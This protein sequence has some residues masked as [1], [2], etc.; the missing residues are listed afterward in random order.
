MQPV[1]PAAGAQQ[2]QAAPYNPPPSVA[3]APL[4]L[5][6]TYG[7]SDAYNPLTS[8]DST[9][10]TSLSSGSKAA[11][12][13]PL[14]IVAL[15]ILALGGVVWY[16]RHPRS[17]AGISRRRSYGEKDDMSL[18]EK[19]MIPGYGRKPS[20]STSIR[21]LASTVIGSSRG[22]TV[23][24]HIDVPDLARPAPSIAPSI[25]SIRRPTAMNLTK[26][27]PPIS[28]Y[29]SNSSG[30]SARTRSTVPVIA[31]ATVARRA[32]AQYLHSPSSP[33]PR[34]GP[35]TIV[36]EGSVRSEEDGESEVSTAYTT[37]P[38]SPRARMRAS[39]NKGYFATSRLSTSS[40]GGIP[41]NRSSPPA[42][43]VYSTHSAP[44]PRSKRSGPSR[45]PIPQHVYPYAQSLPNSI[46]R[47]APVS[48]ARRSPA[49]APALAHSPQSSCE[50]ES[51][52]E[53][54]DF[55]P[56]HPFARKYGASHTSHSSSRSKHTKLQAYESEDA[57]SMVRSITERTELTLPWG[58]AEAKKAKVDDGVKP[59]RQ[60]TKESGVKLFRE[61]TRKGADWARERQL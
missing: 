44:L 3:A 26:P 6:A 43:S 24:P 9:T 57:E 53:M 25:A 39:Q 50:S 16:K 46:A 17:G 45:R 35:E 23:V 58:F 42:A 14:V 20:R 36:E 31:A 29:G 8:P 51:L 4:S 60:E 1:Q 12:A 47:V 34:S 19:A 56:D 15:A 52:P 11:I 27:L 2:P 21:S 49:L 30:S 54:V 10:S 61:E 40:I 22:V 13:V 7:S 18:S 55:P 28:E 59:L 41:I 32:D 48:S 33:R 38:N 37:A 5:P